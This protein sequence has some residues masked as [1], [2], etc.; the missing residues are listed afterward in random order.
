M[1]PPRVFAFCQRKQPRHLDVVN[2][3]D[4][5]KNFQS[6]IVF[7]VFNAV[8]VAGTA[9]HL[10]SDIFI[11]PALLYTQLGYDGSKGLIGRVCLARQL[12]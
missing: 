8:H 10:M 4:C 11:P 6:G 1:P 7:S 2:V 12:T 9:A 3:G 5:L